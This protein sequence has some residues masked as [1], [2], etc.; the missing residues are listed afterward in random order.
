VQARAEDASGNA[1]PGVTVVFSSDF[2][3]LSTTSAVTD[4][5]GVATT[6]LTTSRNSI[7]TAR[8]GGQEATITV[9]LAER[10]GI[11]ITPPSSPPTEGQPTTIQIAVAA[12]ANVQDV[13]VDFGDNSGTISLGRLAGSTTVSHTYESD[14]SFRVTATAVAADGTRESV[15]TSVTVLPQR[16]LS[17][18][19]TVAPRCAV[20]NVTE[21]TFT[22]STSGGTPTG[23]T[24]EFGDGGRAFTTGPTTRYT[25]PAGTTEGQKTARV[26]VSALDAGTGIGETT[27]TVSSTAAGCTGSLAPVR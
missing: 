20:R 9:G 14:G 4:A 11:A 24:W 10:T 25:Y 1:L 12:T 8:A 2:G 21:V 22:A 19:L 17:V 13:I 27:I 15:A 18:T 26:T 3:S 16:P 6:R 5:S 23:Y 7:V